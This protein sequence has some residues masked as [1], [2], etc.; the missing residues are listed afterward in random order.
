M[1]IV[2]NTFV[3]VSRLKVCGD[4]RDI[5]QGSVI[6][7]DILKKGLQTET[8]IANTL[9]DMYAKCDRFLSTTKEIVDD[10]LWNMQ[11]HG[12]YWLQDNMWNM[13]IVR[14][15]SPSL[16]KCKDWTSLQILTLVWCLKACG[17]IRATLEGNEIVQNVVERDYF[18]GNMLVHM[19]A[20][21]GSL[22]EAQVVFQ[23]L[24]IQEHVLWN[25]L[26]AWYAE[27]VL[28]QDGL[29]KNCHFLSIYFVFCSWYAF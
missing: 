10:L 27:N 4:T 5:N 22:A 6:Y 9:V 8:V 17:S 18:I 11:F 13:D 15:H 19:Y 26:I 2:R 24:S 29:G 23:R 25:A 14:Q 1:S 12:I 16:S 20:K 3:L 21:C 28:T 7:D